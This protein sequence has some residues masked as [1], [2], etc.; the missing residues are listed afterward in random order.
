VIDL[1]QPL[2]ADT[3][4][5]ELPSQFGQCDGLSSR[6]VSRY[7]ERGVAGCWNDFEKNEHTPACNSMRRCWVSGRDLPDNATDTIPPAHLMRQQR[8]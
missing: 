5:P 1:K 7:D 4:A 2:S 3:P 8:W 6:K